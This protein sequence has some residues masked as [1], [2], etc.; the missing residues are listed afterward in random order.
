MLRLA[1]KNTVPTSVYTEIENVLFYFINFT[2]SFFAGM[3]FLFYGCN[4]CGDFK[5]RGFTNYHCPTCK[6]FN[7]CKE[8]F[9]NIDHPHE[10]VKIGTDFKGNL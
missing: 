2:H 7:L 3:I 9:S 4:L 8:C 6:N 5:P 1:I 10:M